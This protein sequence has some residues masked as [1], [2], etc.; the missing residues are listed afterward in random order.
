MPPK[1]A[2]SAKSKDKG[3]NANKDNAG[4]NNRSHCGHIAHTAPPKPAVVDEGTKEYY[5]MQIRDLETRVARYI[6]LRIVSENFH[7]SVRFPV[8][9]VSIYVTL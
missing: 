1:R 5:L 3:T 4:N 8:F 9:S 7:A 6:I 2:A